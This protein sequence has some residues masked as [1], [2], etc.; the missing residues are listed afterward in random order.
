MSIDNPFC[1]I[2][3]ALPVVCAIFNLKASAL[4]LFLLICISTIALTACR[5]HSFR[6]A[7][8]LSKLICVAMALMPTLLGIMPSFMLLLTN[9]SV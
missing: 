8:H 5:L 3:I 1:A 2:Y 9:F 4:E 6:Q 7:I